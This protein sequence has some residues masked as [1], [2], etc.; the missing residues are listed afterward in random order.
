MISKL[1]ALDEEISVL[2]THVLGK[3]PHQVVGVPYL[4]GC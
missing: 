2:K 4:K 1:T 3:P